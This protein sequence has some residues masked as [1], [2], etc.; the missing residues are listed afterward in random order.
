MNPPRGATNARQQRRRVV[1]LS[2]LLLGALSGCVLPWDGDPG[3]APPDITQPTGGP[4]PPVGPPL[5]FGGTLVDAVSGALLADA[6]VRVDLSQALPCGNQGIGWSSWHPPAANGTWGPLEVPRPRSD[7][8]AFF[9]HAMAEGY[10]TNDT[11][12][13][14]AQARGDIRNMTLVLHP[15]AA[16]EGVAPPGT[17]VALDAPPFPR[18]A[19]ANASGAFRFPGARVVDASLVAATDDPHR[20]VVAAPANVTVPQAQARGWLLEGIVKGPTGAG[21]AAD[22]VAW[23]GTRLW[24]VARSN[25]AGAFAMPLTAAPAALRIEARTSD[26]H[27]GGVL[28][29]AIQG[30]PALRETILAKALC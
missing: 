17:L 12:I 4:P 2:W 26:G 9:V 11:F 8:V 23:N 14:A 24:S 22:V 7:D 3:D 27:Y 10:T 28:S 18:V 16:V 15:R 13:G 20:E 6:T 1:A 21:I 19:H 5:R 29:L 30:P 25:D